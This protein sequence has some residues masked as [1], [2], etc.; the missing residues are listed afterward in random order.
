LRRRAPRHFWGWL[1]NSGQEAAQRRD[2]RLPA[3]GT[4]LKRRYR[5]EE[6][7]VRV[8]EDGFTYDQRRFSSLSAIAYEVTGTRWNGYLFFGLQEWQKHE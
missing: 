6:I 8:E 1:E 3:P 4:E 7:V 2:P 5:G